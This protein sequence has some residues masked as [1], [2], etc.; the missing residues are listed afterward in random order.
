[1]PVLLIEDNPEDREAI[2]RAFQE[3]GPPCSLHYC[4]TGDDGIDFLFRRGKYSLPESAPRPALIVLDLNLPGTGGREVLE[5]IKGDNSLGVIPVV[6]LTTSSDEGDI[7]SCY[8]SGVSSY[9]QK[10]VELRAFMETI[11]RLAE[12]WLETV[13]LP[14][15]P[16]KA[17]DL[18]RQGPPP[19]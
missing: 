15:D 9:L 12:Y 7:Q 3:A 17:G 2:R 11:R 6:V 16:Q 8:R 5:T 18:T 14:A 4:V 10:P 1:M 19:R 13:I